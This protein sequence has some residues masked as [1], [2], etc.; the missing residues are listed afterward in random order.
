MVCAFSSLFLVWHTDK[1]TRR[2]SGFTSFETVL[3]NKNRPSG[4]F[5]SPHEHICN[6]CAQAH[7]PSLFCTN[8]TSGSLNTLKNR[9]DAMDF[10]GRISSQGL[11]TQKYQRIYQS[12]LCLKM[13]DDILTH[14]NVIGSLCGS[15]FL[16]SILCSVI[17][18]K[19]YTLH[20]WQLYPM[21]LIAKTL[22]YLTSNYEVFISMCL[23]M[24]KDWCII[25]NSLSLWILF[26][27]LA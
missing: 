14:W 16:E 5:P 9:R 6:V 12:F 13:I 24:H 15:D 22:Q 27:D 1:C 3:W 8:L 25:L 4:F 11:L 23:L 17:Q 2:Q 7:L 10:N 18:E 20:Q 26:G 21:L 19:N